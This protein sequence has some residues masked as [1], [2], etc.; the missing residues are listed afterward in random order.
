M[1]L[2]TAIRFAVLIVLGPQYFVWVVLIWLSSR[3]TRVTELLVVTRLKKVARAASRKGLLDTAALSTLRQKI[4]TIN[5]ARDWLAALPTIGH[6]ELGA[7]DRLISKPKFLMRRVTTSG[8]SGQPHEY[9]VGRFRYSK[10]YAFLHSAWA[11]SGYRTGVTRM[12]LRGFDGNGSKLVKRFANEIRASVLDLRPQNLDTF[13]EIIK[14]QRVR[15]LHGY[16]SA[17]TTL[18]NRMSQSPTSTRNMVKGVFLVSEAASTDQRGQIKEAFPEATIVETY[19]QTE[20]VGFAYRP[21]GTEPYSF[22][23]L[24]GIIELIDNDNLP[25]RLP[26]GR[27]RLVGTALLH[28]GLPVIRLE[29]GDYATLHEAP[30]E[31]NGWALKVSNI[32]S[33]WDLPSALGTDGQLVSLTAINSHT[34]DFVNFLEYQFV[35][36]QI[37]HLEF[38]Y[39]TVP[40]H[41]ER[42]VQAAIQHLEE[43]LGSALHL[44]PIREQSL[45]SNARGK[46]PLFR[47]EIDMTIT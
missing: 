24:Y 40:N 31:A 4:R 3:S 22:S 8:S 2:S 41:S 5:D 36:R 29:L 1:L 12:V 44:I 6:K 16:P 19:G 21:S 27:G 45:R 39:V 23:P 10:E 38:H 20:K 18:A 14:R 13:S 43:K 30:S 11:K 26:G 46:L 35:Q 28:Q 32:S 42:G 37:G 34:A 15:Y 47:Q 25:I 9:F 17:I 33:R 7:L